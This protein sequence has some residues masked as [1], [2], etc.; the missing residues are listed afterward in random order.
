MK[1]I[2]LIGMKSS[3][4][5]RLSS[6]IAEHVHLTLLQVDDGIGQQYETEHH[7]HLSNRQIVEQHGQ[8]FFREMESAVLQRMSVEH[9]SDVVVDCGGG[10]PMRKA[11]QVIL[12]NMGTILWLKLDPEINF[13]RIMRKGIPSIFADKDNPR[14]SFRQLIEERFP[15]YQQLADHILNIQ[16]E[17][18]EETF[19]KFLA[20]NLLT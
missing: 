6:Q 10:L 16:N 19:Q 1:N 2:I 8:D 17:S 13:E 5:S 11:N 15:I 9:H 20:L 14:A 7:Q 4:K 18:E 12:K 3:G